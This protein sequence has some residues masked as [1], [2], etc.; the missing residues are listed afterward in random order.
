MSSSIRCELCHVDLSS[1]A[2]MAEHI[3]GKKHEK[4]AAQM[5]TFTSLAK[6]SIFLSGVPKNTFSSEQQV[7]DLVVNFGS[8]ERVLLDSKRGT[9]AIV[10]FN[11]ESSALKAIAEG[12]IR[13]NGHYALIK[14]R[15]MEFDNTEKKFE[16]ESIDVEKVIDRMASSG[17]SYEE[18]IDEL[19]RHFC[20]SEQQLSERREYANNLTNALSEYFASDTHVCLF[21]SS[22]TSVGTVDSD[23]DASILFGDEPLVKSERLNPF[24]RNKFTLMTCEV[25]TIRVRKVCA[26]ELAR[27]TPADRIRFVT[28][29]LN[30]IRRRGT[31][32]ISDQYPVLDARCPLVRFLFDRK[33]TFDL[34]VDNR[35]G[36]A[37]SVWLKEL[38][39][40]DPS[41]KLR[42]FLVAVRFWALVNGLMRKDEKTRSQFNAYIV[43][44]LCIVYLQSHSHLRPLERGPEPICVDGWEVDFTVHRTDHFSQLRVCSLL[45]DFF[46]WFI[47]LKLRNNVLCPRLGSILSKE[48]FIQAFPEA[49]VQ[50]LFKFTTLNIQDPLELSHN[51]SQLISE[52]YLSEM[53]RTMMITLSSIKEKPNCFV[54][55]LRH[56]SLSPSLCSDLE[57][58]LPC[59]GMTADECLA[60]LERI[61]VELLACTPIDEPT[62]KRMKREGAPQHELSKCFEVTQRVWIGRRGKRRLVSAENPTLSE[63]QIEKAVSK[64]IYEENTSDMMLRFC[65]FVLLQDGNAEMRLSRLSGTELDLHNLAHFLSVFIP[66]HFRH[67]DAVPSSYDVIPME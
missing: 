33:H 10:E 19:I 59:G 52:K 45:K 3:K 38:I 53:R 13:V 48:E 24:A 32:P 54:T 39:G 61:L 44:M 35:L 60:L 16:K 11:E 55:A 43:N 2:Q 8:V 6:R 1:E 5:Y 63:W 36:I 40:A 15:K 66:K 67:T 64:A 26:D 22:I 28:K 23:I 37:K 21:G 30:E 20:L 18:Q 62:R 51:I 29:I 56:Q 46:V 12:K 47:Q 65:L 31:A 7:R 58:R 57:I 27:L 50:Q 9:F 25:A 34:S 41:G 42:Q 4:K 49:V 14:E 17:T